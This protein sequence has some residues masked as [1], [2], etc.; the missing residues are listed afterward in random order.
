MV[1]GGQA[2]AIASAG[3]VA[4]LGGEKLVDRLFEPA[5]QQVK[6]ALVGHGAAGA[7]GSFC[8]R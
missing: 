6:I 1:G 4:L 2:L 7:G 5:V 3:A 8:G